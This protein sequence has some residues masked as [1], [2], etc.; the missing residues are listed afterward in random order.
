MV[1]AT[2][3]GSAGILS[4]L[5]LCFGIGRQHKLIAVIYLCDEIGTG[6]RGRREWEELWCDGG[7]GERDRSLL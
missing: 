2:R 1:A 6:E 3:G 4:V 5:S 7:G